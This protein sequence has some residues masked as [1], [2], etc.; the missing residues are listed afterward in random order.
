MEVL[1]IAYLIF[2]NGSNHDYHFI[3]KEFA[4]EF[5]KQFTSLGENTAKYITFT[6]PIE[7]K[8]T[9]IN[10]NGEEVTKVYPTY[11]NLLI[12]QDLWQVHY[13]I[14]S[15]IFLNL[16]EEIHR[17]KCKFGHDGKKCEICG[18]KC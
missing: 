6:V 9:R 16:S 17:I 3:M 13:Q 14:L 8:V 11:Y 18:I 15:L 4:E 1:H 5:K 12:S 7:K 2:H 10:K